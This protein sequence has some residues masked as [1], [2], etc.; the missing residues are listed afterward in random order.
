MRILSLTY[1]FIIRSLFIIDKSNSL[2]FTGIFNKLNKY[3]LDLSKANNFINRPNK[4]NKVI[5][6]NP[7]IQEYISN[8]DVESYD[9]S[10]MN[11]FT[12]K[13]NFI[14]SVQTNQITINT[15]ESFDKMM[16][17]FNQFIENRHNIF[18]N[19]NKK[20]ITITPGGL[21]G[22]YV[23][24]ICTFIKESYS[25]DNYIFSGASAG[26][27]NSLIMSYKYKDHKLIDSIFDIEF[28]KANSIFEVELMIKNKILKDFSNNDFFLDRIYIGSTIVDNYKFKSIVYSN[29]DS[30]SDAIDCC[31]GSSHIPLISG[32]TVYIYRNKFTL[33]GGFS[34]FFNQSPYLPTKIPSLIINPNLFKNI[35]EESLDL[36]DLYKGYYDSLDIK[37]IVNAKK[38]FDDGYENAKNNKHHLDQIFK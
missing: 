30:L 6:T 15:K 20:L 12:N 28:D 5:Y 19:D 27:W 16:L 23:L 21:K 2:K 37:K 31:I 26:S 24:G 17:N 36:C 35:E 29:F 10:L 25:L 9:S 32:K 34:L 4:I 38:M 8:K 7:S 14:N 22:F 1:L 13:I 33:D 18:F 11:S 3:S